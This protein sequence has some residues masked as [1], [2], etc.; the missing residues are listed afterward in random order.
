M[1]QV[2]E[3]RRAARRLREARAKAEKKRREYKG[4]V[5]EAAQG[6]RG[7][8]AAHSCY[9]VEISVLC[10]SGNEVCVCVRVCVCACMCACMRV[11]LSMCVRVYVCI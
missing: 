10:S 9:L 1:R 5:A 2:E 8:R 6:G 7:L 3:E 4:L 11:C